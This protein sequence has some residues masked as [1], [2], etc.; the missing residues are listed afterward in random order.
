MKT[1]TGWIIPVM[2]KLVPGHCLCNSIIKENSSGSAPRCLLSDSFQVMSLF[3]QSWIKYETFVFSLVTTSELS[4]WLMWSHI[5]NW[6]TVHKATFM[7]SEV[8]LLI[9]YL[10][11]VH[12]LSW[13][14][15]THHA[16]CHAFSCI[17]CNHCKMQASCFRLSLVNV[18]KYTHLSCLS[19]C[20]CP[21]SPEPSRVC[22]GPVWGPEGGGEAPPLHREDPLHP[23]S[24]HISGLQQQCKEGV[25]QHP[26]LTQCD[27]WK[28][29]GR[30]TD[31]LH[32]EANKLTLTTYNSRQIQFS[33]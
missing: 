6:D 11:V 29:F 21:Q 32:T 8:N 13:V 1:T 26:S 31:R 33:V 15:I 25:K 23:R 19:V 3:V 7:F 24:G 30:K 10:S 28:Q 27:T 5:W 16:L 18:C 9:L 14:K 12:S 2:Y 22:G 20:V 17:C 4:W